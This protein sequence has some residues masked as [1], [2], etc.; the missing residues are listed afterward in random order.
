M[1]NAKSVLGSLDQELVW[2]RELY[3]DL[4]RHPELSLQEER[5]AGR[6]EQELSGFGYNV[7]R[8]GGTGVVGVLANG[9][10]STVLA[11]ADTDALPVTEATGLDYASTV[12]G[13]M[14]AC[15]HD[16]HIVSLLG[17]AKLMAGGRDAWSG[18]YV[19]LFQ[20][21]EETAAGSRAM[22]DDGLADK[23]PRPDVAFAQHVMPKEA[24]MIGTTA[25]PVLSAGDSL[26][27]T[28]F[29]RGAHGS[30]PHLAVDPVVL[31]ASIVLRLQTIVSRET[32]PGEFAVVT[33]GASN[34]GTKSNIIPD[35]AELLLNLRTYDEA[36]RKRIMASIERIV[37]GE[38]AAAGSP[39]EPEFEYYD[40]F[41]LTS[42]D[43][44]TT[45][46]VTA[47]FTEHFGADAV[48]HADPVTA[49][50]DFSRI[51]AAFGVP[52]TYWIV[53]SVPPEAYRRAVENGTVSQ[54]IPANHSPF[55]AP[56]I[57]PTLGT[58]TQAQV[59]AALSYLSK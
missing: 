51:P 3:K 16:M 33:V 14:H 7:Q 21:A 9:P 42:N 49:S 34:A 54:D 25:G 13:V 40:Q 19:A 56:A 32:Q 6:I 27:I 1:A 22:V 44:D 38:C 4:H 55:F 47:A 20:P 5:T 11:R 23:V 52:Y 58:A 57:D 29:G 17:A 46:R 30:M 45:Q 26:K 41:P 37:K 35:R 48:F 39:R 50:E 36:L 24:G 43:A 2:Q 59:V 15:G 8:I 18:T 53:G 28:V 31:A 10:G 12:E